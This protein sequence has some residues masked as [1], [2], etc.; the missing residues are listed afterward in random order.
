MNN[1]Q[2]KEYVEGMKKGIEKCVCVKCENFEAYENEGEAKELCINE[3]VCSYCEGIRDLLL[4]KVLGDLEIPIGEETTQLPYEIEAVLYKHTE[5][6]ACGYT[7]IR[8][9]ENQNIGDSYT[10]VSQEIAQKIKG[11]HQT[12]KV[13][14]AMKEEKK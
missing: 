12:V 10:I 4:T 11:Y 1:Q 2:A 3:G 14:D 6:L 8:C 13:K 5:S 7:G 9:E